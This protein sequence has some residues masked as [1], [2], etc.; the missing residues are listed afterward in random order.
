[1]N[2]DWIVV[3]GTGEILLGRRDTERLKI[4]RWASNGQYY[5][6][7]DKFYSFARQYPDGLG[8]TQFYLQQH[9]MFKGCQIAH[10]IEGRAMSIYTSSCAFATSLGD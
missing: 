9:W 8:R 2:L 7:G 4:L 1:M 5:F 10:Y 3:H 6:F